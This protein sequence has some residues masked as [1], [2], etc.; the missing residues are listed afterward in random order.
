MGIHVIN[1]LFLTNEERQPLQSM[2]MCWTGSDDDEKNSVVCHVLL[3]IPGLFVDQ[4]NFVVEWS[5][6]GHG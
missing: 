4:A 3:Y 6:L 5:I 2:I 1:T